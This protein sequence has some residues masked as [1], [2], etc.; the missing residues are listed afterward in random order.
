[1]APDGA[2]GREMAPSHSQLSSY[3]PLALAS[4]ATSASGLRALGTSLENA[5]S[6]QGL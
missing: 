4:K 6:L 3:V 5:V 2:N 1:M